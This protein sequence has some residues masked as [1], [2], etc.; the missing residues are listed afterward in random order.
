V[1]STTPFARPMV[2]PRATCGLLST[3]FRNYGDVFPGLGLRG[4]A[5]WDLSLAMST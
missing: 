4:K 3:P 2:R 1:T 5:L